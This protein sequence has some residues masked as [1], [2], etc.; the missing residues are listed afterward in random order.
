MEPPHPYGELERNWT[1]EGLD[2]GTEVRPLSSKR[3]HLRAEVMH[4]Q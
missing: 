2:K 4:F 1:G 3:M